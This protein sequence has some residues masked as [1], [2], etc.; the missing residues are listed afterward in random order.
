M[1]Y[2]V[3]SAPH[4]SPAVS[5]LEREQMLYKEFDKLDDALGWARRLSRSNRVALAIAGDDGTSL[6][7]AD[8]AA[9]LRH[10]DTAE[11]ERTS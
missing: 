10:P 3:Y 2:R 6:T 4:G 8:I 11:F 1:G 7:K 9:A 5:A